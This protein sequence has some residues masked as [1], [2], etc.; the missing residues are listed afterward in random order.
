MTDKLK[1][2]FLTLTEIRK[3]AGISL[4]WA[5]H[6]ALRG[7]VKAIRAKDGSLRIA[8][9]EA[10]R[11]KEFVKHPRGKVS[12]FLKTLG[13]GLITGASDD[14]PSGIGTYSAVGAQFGFSILWMA[15]YLLPVMMAIQEVCARIGIVTRKG[16]AGVLLE[17]YR[18]KVVL[19]IVFLLIIANSFSQIL[20]EVRHLFICPRVI[21]LVRWNLEVVMPQNP[22]DSNLFK[23]Y[24]WLRLFHFIKGFLQRMGP[25]FQP[26]PVRVLTPAGAVRAPKTIGRCQPNQRK[27]EM[28]PFQIV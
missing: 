21:S 8:A 16:L 22:A 10:E 6:L 12:L 24:W 26:L 20:K 27:A 3:K 25:A 1:G 9:V 5:K 19:G 23:F 13:P 11:I 2:K 15:A 7:Q 18:R 14:D 17:H 28:Q 4:V